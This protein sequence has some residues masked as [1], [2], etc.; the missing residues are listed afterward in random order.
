[1]LNVKKFKRNVVTLYLFVMPMLAQAAEKSA[2]KDG[3][4]KVMGVGAVIAFG[5]GVFCFYEGVKH[6]R[7]GQPIGND[8]IAVLLCAGGIA[9]CTL[10]FGAFSLSDATVPASF[11][12]L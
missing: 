2:F 8:I 3:L 5:Y 1:M 9:I 6:W 11:D 7:N 10:I 12:G 4:G